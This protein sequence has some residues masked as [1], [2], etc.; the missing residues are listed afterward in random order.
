MITIQTTE[1][2]LTFS[3]ELIAA[4]QRHAIRQADLTAACIHAIE[5]LQGKLVSFPA[6]FLLELA[7][8]LE[9][10]VWEKQGVSRRLVADLPTF[11]EAKKNLAARSLKGPAE[12]AG[13]DASPLSSRVARVWIDNFA[14][15]APDT[16]G[17]EIVLDE[18]DQDDDDF[19]DLL[20][21]YVWTHRQELQYLISEKR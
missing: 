21:E 18:G 2:P 12:F 5:G 20:A 16:L 1:G 3:D 15:D 13:P 8:V 11:A 9:L 7:A 4:I 10:G 14:W 19:L 17:T 6:A